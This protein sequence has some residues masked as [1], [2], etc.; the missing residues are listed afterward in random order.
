[1]LLSR[2]FYQIYERQCDG[3]RGPDVGRQ[4]CEGRRTTTA[5]AKLKKSIW[6]DVYLELHSHVLVEEILE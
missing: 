3:H 4:I 6:H 2:Y 5:V 1:M